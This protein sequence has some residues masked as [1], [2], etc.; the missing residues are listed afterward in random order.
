MQGD[1]ENDI[2]YGGEGN[3]YIQ[4]DAGNDKLYG[5]DGND[6]LFGGPGKDIF[7]CN[8]GNDIIIDFNT[9]DDIKSSNCNIIKN[10]QENII[11]V[12]TKVPNRNQKQLSPIVP[13]LFPTSN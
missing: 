13:S 5:N 10:V 3:D 12:L 8:P 2:I 11:D 7:F 4:G 9:R 6:I 1:A